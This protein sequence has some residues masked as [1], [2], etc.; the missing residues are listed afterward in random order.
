[1]TLGGYFG[2]ADAGFTRHFLCPAASGDPDRVDTYESNQSVTTNSYAM[3]KELAL[4]RPEQLKNSSGKMYLADVW[5]TKLSGGE[6]YFGYEANY[7]TWNISRRHRNGCNILWADFH[8]SNA[9]KSVVQNTKY[10]NL[11]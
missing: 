3:N 2:K 11:P 6:S 4:K 8:V 10:I 9:L 1:M 5:N 7:L